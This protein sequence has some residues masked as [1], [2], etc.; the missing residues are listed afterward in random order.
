VTGHGEK[1]TRRY[2][3]ALA[4]LL[5]EPTLA[6]AAA[7]TGVSEATLARWLRRDDFRRAFRAARRE[8]VESAIG[9]LQGATE[10]AVEALRRNLSSESGSIQVRAA[11][12]ILAHATK[13]IE[14]MDLVERV[15]SLE[16]QQAHRG[17][18]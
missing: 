3:H 9:K 1:L 16:G 2:E 4:A 7:R 8:V 14:L 18:A 6:G 15:E 5:T 17:A 10:E 12:A 13:A 11:C